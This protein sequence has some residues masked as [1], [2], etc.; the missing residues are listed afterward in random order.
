MFVFDNLLGVTENIFSLA[1]CLPYNIVETNKL[2]IEVGQA[3]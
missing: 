3:R 1:H 2:F